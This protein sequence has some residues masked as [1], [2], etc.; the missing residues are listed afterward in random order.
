MTEQEQKKKRRRTQQQQQQEQQQVSITDI[1]LRVQELANEIVNLEHEEGEIRRTKKLR[2]REMAYHLREKYL[3]L[4]QPENIQFI[5]REIHNMEQFRNEENI[6]IDVARSLDSEFKPK[7][8]ARE[9]YDDY[10]GVAFATS[11]EVQSR[12]TYTKETLKELVDTVDPFEQSIRGNQEAAELVEKFQIK[13]EKW[14]KDTGN[15]LGMSKRNPKL[16]DVE[17]ED[18]VTLEPAPPLETKDLEE[19]KDLFIKQ[20]MEIGDKFHRIAKRAKSHNYVPRSKESLI[21]AIKE[22]QAI[23]Y[24]IEP[25]Y[26]TKWQNDIPQSINVYKTYWKYGGSKSYAA[27]KSG[28]PVADVEVNPKTGKIQ[29]R[30]LTKEEI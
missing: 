1:D 11:E 5:C 2:Y 25:Y 12:D 17:E 9:A 16:N 3:K 23:L 21:R 26:D 30:K 15:H 20:R 13:L 24:W 28:M 27:S 6:R 4:G 7:R 14:S 18:K 10:E 29:L 8:E 22:G 19:L